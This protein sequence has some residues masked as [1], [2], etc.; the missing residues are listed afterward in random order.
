[1]VER[2]IVEEDGNTI[3]DFFL[4]AN[5]NPSQACAQP[6]KYSV[7]INTTG[8]Q[9]SDIEEFTYQMCYHYYGFGGPV[10]VPHVVMYAHKMTNYVADNK[11]VD[12]NLTQKPNDDLS[13]KLHVL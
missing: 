5:Q 2:G 1:M 11:F 4:V 7:R 3:F 8:I 10:K 13:L 12:T 9:K 6:V